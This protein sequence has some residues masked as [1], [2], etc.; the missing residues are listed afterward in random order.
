MS[1]YRQLLWRQTKG[2]TGIIK[3]TCGPRKRPYSLA[4]SVRTVRPGPIIPAVPGTPEAPR[5]ANK[6][7]RF[8]GR[9]CL[10][11][12]VGKG[13]RPGLTIG[14]RCGMSMEVLTQG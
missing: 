11:G 6:N 7:R 13:S 9:P 12:T 14:M 10:P 5:T 1:C 8:S 3:E 2:P 4:A